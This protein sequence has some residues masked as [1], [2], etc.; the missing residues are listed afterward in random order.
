MSISDV[1]LTRRTLLGAGALALAGWPR[2]A[3]A[4]ELRFSRDPFALGVASGSPAAERVVIWT[5]LAPDPLHGGGMPE[6]RVPVAWEVAED[7]KFSRIVQRGV[8]QAVPDLGHSVHAEVQGLKPDRSY[9]YRSFA[10][11]EASP[12]GRTKTLPRADAEVK[13][14]R[15]AFGSCQHYEHG[16][17]AAHRHLLGEELDLMIFLGD[18]IYEATWGSNLVRQHV[19]ATCGSLAPRLPGSLRAIPHRS[20]SRAAPRCGAVGRRLGRSRGRQRLRRTHRR[21]AR[22]RLRLA[23]R[24]RVSSVLGAHASAPVAATGAR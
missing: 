9:W 2:S 24:R 14:W 8:E 7:D 3:R 22:A 5:R 10:G 4:D 1:R 19:P 15:L 6:A 12:I 11:R 18:Y 20:G 21:I 23:P 17:F 16:W 13:R